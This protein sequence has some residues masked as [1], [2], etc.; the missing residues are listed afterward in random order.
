[1]ADAVISGEESD[2][3]KSR[4]WSRGAL[5]AFDERWFLNMF[6]IGGRNALTL[7]HVGRLPVQ[8]HRPCSQPN[9][10]DS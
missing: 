8:Q 9:D 7:S 5:K 3:W 2:L 4:L 10:V 6:L 1:M